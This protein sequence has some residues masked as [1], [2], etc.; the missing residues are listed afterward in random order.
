M[1]RTITLIS[2]ILL[3][4][5]SSIGVCANFEECR[6]RG[7]ENRVYGANNSQITRLE[8]NGTTHI[9]NSS[10]NSDGTRLVRITTVGK[11]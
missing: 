4:G 6:Q 5:C 7:W 10:T 3:T 8:V 9:V 2:V 1:L 11:K